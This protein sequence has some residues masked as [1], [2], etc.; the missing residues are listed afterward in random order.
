[1]SRP[2]VVVSCCRNAPTCQS[3]ALYGR[4]RLMPA[5]D[6]CGWATLERVTRTRRSLQPEVPA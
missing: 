2:D 6:T 1:M 4:M 5:V 3:W